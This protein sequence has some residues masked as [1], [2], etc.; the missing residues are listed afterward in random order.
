[1]IA[2]STV[3]SGPP[4]RVNS[5]ANPISV[6]AI[7]PGIG[8]RATARRTS[9]Y[10]TRISPIVMTDDPIPKAKMTAIGFASVK[11]WSIAEVMTIRMPCTCVR[12]RASTLACSVTVTR[13]QCGSRVNR[14]RARSKRRWARSASHAAVRGWRSKSH[15][16]TVDAVRT[17]LAAAMTTMNTRRSTTS[18]A[19]PAKPAIDV[20]NAINHSLYAATTL[21]VTIV[22]PT[23]VSDT[24]QLFSMAMRTPVLMGPLPT[25]VLFAA[26]AD[27]CTIAPCTQVMPGVTALA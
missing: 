21:S 23:E 11:T 17:T 24:R 4:N 22:R 20:A 27:C 5:A 10:A 16:S 14:R 15:H 3:V 25:T 8:V 13:S 19:A 18:P 12:S 26:V 1:M 9:P 6:T 7:P 2:A